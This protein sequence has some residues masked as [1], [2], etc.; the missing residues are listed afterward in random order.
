MICG[1]LICEILPTKI[2]YTYKRGKFFLI[3]LFFLVLVFR[4]YRC[5]L[6]VYYG[7]HEHQTFSESELPSRFEG[8]KSNG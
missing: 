7:V 6:V 5:H 4:E 3:F 1:H 2:Q 8:R